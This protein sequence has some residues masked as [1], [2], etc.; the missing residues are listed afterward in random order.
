MPRIL[1]AQPGRWRTGYALVLG[2]VPEVPSVTPATPR[3]GRPRSRSNLTFSA[4]PRVALARCMPWSISRHARSSV[5]AALPC[6]RSTRYT[7]SAR[8]R[9]D[10]PCS[11]LASPRRLRARKRVVASTISVSSASRPRLHRWMQTACD[12]SLDSAF[13]VN[14][15]IGTTLLHGS[16]RRMPYHRVFQHRG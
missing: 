3:S 10:R 15:R 13:R 11:A 1:C 6:A 7:P 9:P 12:P 16:S 4:S 5:R 14:E 2:L 8:P